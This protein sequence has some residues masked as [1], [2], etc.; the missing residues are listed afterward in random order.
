MNIDE[1]AGE[2]MALLDFKKWLESK[3]EAVEIDLAINEQEAEDI[4][5]EMEKE[6]K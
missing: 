1:L 4:L 6:L 3:L 2:H 5:N